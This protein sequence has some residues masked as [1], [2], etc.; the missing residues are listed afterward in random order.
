MTRKKVAVRPKNKSSA[1]STGGPDVNRRAAGVNQEGQYKGA[2]K[3]YS[4]T[5]ILKE[6]NR[7]WAED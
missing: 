1:G 4:N 6:I 5:E 3:T 7:R 2:M